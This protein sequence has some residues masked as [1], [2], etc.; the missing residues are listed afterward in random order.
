[1]PPE[2]RTALL[3]GQFDFLGQLLEG[4]PQIRALAGKLPYLNQFA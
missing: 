4:E 2:A 3:T 1:M